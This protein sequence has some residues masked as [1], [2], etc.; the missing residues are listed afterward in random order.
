MTLLEDLGGNLRIE[1]GSRYSTAAIG[2][3][4]VI[5]AEGRDG[6][7]GEFLTESASKHFG[8]LRAKTH[9]SHITSECV[10]NTTSSTGREIQYTNLA[11][12]CRP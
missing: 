6:M 4:V 3:R 11:I 8:M 5:D 2:R 7:R 12:T 9:R 1:A 10:Y